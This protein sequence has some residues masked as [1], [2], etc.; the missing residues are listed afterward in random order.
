MV[1]P[2]TLWPPNGRQ[3]PVTVRGVVA[4][5]GDVSMLEYSVKDSEANDQ[6]IR[7][8]TV[9]RFNQMNGRYS[10]TIPL[11]ASRSGQDRSGRV[12]TIDVSAVD[13]SGQTTGEQMATVV[14]PHD[15]GRHGGGGKLFG[16][17][18]GQGAGGSGG[19]GRMSSPSTANPG[20]FRFGGA[21][22]GQTNTATLSGSNNT[23]TQN[24]NNTQT[25]NFFFQDN[26]TTTHSPT[27]TRPSS[28]DGGDDQG[29][30]NDQGD[31]GSSGHDHGHGNGHDNGKGHG[32]HG[33]S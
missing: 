3:V 30:D 21:G 1:R 14:V 31:G 7:S 23:L 8:G 15:R 4:D 17:G 22:Q 6:V 11:Q 26:S 5:P 29:D 24:I 18:Q 10:I 20:G 25:N 16:N 12:Y 28:G 27:S 2:T 19:S 33:D 9:T 32:K 13:D